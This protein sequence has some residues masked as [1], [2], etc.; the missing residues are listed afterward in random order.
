MDDK[1]KEEPVVIPPTAKPVAPRPMQL[2]GVTYGVETP[3]GKTYITINHNDAKEP[4]EVFITIGKSGSD[5]AA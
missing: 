3:V 5:V 2:E 4:F 1:K